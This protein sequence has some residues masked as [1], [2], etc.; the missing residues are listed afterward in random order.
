MP[1]RF[2]CPCRQKL[3][4][5]DEAAGKRAK[6]P[7]CSRWLR[8]PES[9]SYE[10]VAEEVEPGRLAEKE[11]GAAEPAQAEPAPPPEERRE[12]VKGRVVVADSNPSDLKVTT[13]ILRD[14]GYEVLEAEDG[15]RAV[16]MIRKELPDAAVLDVRLDLLGGFKVIE[17]IRNPADVRNKQVWDMPVLMT[18]VKLR[19][20]DKQYAMSLGVKGFF[21]KPVTPATLCSRLEKE[22]SR[23]RR[24]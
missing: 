8:V 12:G 10:T 3:K 9:G 18:T 2:R 1:I 16:E 17:Q 6:C 24:R 5:S 4:A 22:L 20:R 7:K 14:H 11:P 13:R 23:R 15:A 21:S 19:G